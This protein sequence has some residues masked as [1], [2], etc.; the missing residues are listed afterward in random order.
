MSAATPLAV[1]L[2]E[3]IATAGPITF[4]A[5]MAQALYHPEL[6]YYSSAKVIGKRGDFFTNVSVGPIFGALIARQ[7][8]E[9]WRCLGEP[10][11]FT[12]IEQGAHHGDFAR[13]ALTSLRSFA[14]TCFAAVDYR[15]I[16]PVRALQAAQARTL[17][18]F[19]EKVSW[20]DS[21]E[22]S[23][24]FT[25][26]HFSN[27]LLD[28]LPVHRIVLRA[29]GW[30]EQYV[31]VDEQRFVFVDGPLCTDALGAQIARLP[32]MPLGYQT[33]LNL[34][35]LNWIDTLAA[36]L[37]RGFALTIDYGF[38]RSEYYAP[39]RSTGTLAAYARHRR[40]DD[41]LSLTG[42]VD[43]TAHVEFTSVAER[44]IVNGLR[45]HGFT[46]QHHFMVGLSRLHFTDS[47]ALT[48]AEQRERAAFKMLMHPALMGLSFKA[49][50]F[51]KGIVQTSPLSGF[52][53]ARDASLA[54]EIPSEKARL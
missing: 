19:T 10:D 34:P 40:V 7:F 32:A 16:E 18:S 11:R 5:F 17:T 21:L 47:Q 13:D 27:E 4:R 54:L 20:N 3:A 38:S 30:K 49:L 35:A 52:G 45:L 46:D 48:A 2:R 51:D 1:L 14:P 12:I 42:E 6:G 33:E 44:A 43:L 26:V 15:L 22:E 8:E 9:M 28:A 31:A 24:P 29:D 50:C 53:F 37:V 25:G 41:V 39:A 23:E 36:K